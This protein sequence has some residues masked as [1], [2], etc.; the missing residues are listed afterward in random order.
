M[1]ATLQQAPVQTANMSRDGRFIFIFFSPAL[2]K[3]LLTARGEKATNCIPTSS[4]TL[5]YDLR[6]DV[7]EFLQ[8]Q[9]NA[10]QFKFIY[11]ALSTMHTNVSGTKRLYR[12]LDGDL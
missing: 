3:S 1:N 2:L 10:I 11:I 4:L 12:N 8:V 9:F 6:R 7:K 5:S